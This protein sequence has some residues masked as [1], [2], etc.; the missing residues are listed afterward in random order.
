M[1]FSSVRKL[2]WQSPPEFQIFRL[3][4]T[5][6]PEFMYALNRSETLDRLFGSE[7]ISDSVVTTVLA[8]ALQV[9]LKH[10]YIYIYIAKQKEIHDEKCYEKHQPLEILHELYNAS[11]LVGEV[12]IQRRIFPKAN[13]TI[14]VVARKLLTAVGGM[15][16]TDGI[17]IYQGPTAPLPNGI[18]TYTVQILNV[19]LSGCSISNIHVSCEWFSSARL[20]NPKIFRRLCYNDCL[21]NNGEA[22][23]PGESLTFQYANSFPYPLSIS[24]ISCS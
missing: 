15:C 14:V 7:K 11:E 6:F 24:S 16:S 22:L 18:P 20:I 4:T 2:Q 5:Y 13:R 17:A 1:P 23:V 9:I 12:R 21:A 3:P 10:I 8:F 19:C